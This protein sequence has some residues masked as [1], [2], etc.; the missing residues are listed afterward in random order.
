MR[1]RIILFAFRIEKKTAE[2]KVK[3]LGIQKKNWEKENIPPKMV[4]IYAALCAIVAFV[5]T[6]QLMLLLFLSDP[7]LIIYKH[8]ESSEILFPEMKFRDEGAPERLLRSVSEPAKPACSMVYNVSVSMN[9]QIKMNS[10]SI[11]VTNEHECRLLTFV[12]ESGMYKLLRYPRESIL[13]LFERKDEYHRQAF[14][15]LVRLLS[16][17]ED[18]ESDAL[19][20]DV[21]SWEETMIVLPKW[22]T[23]TSYIFFRDDPDLQLQ[24]RKVVIQRVQQ[25]SMCHMYAPAILQY[26]L[27]SKYSHMRSE[28]SIMNMAKFVR[29]EYN[30]QWL[31]NHVFEGKGILSSRFLSLILRP[32]KG[33]GHRVV[34]F[35]EIDETMLRQYGPLLLSE[36]AVCDDF[37]VEGRL[38]YSLDGCNATKPGQGPV[39]VGCDYVVFENRLTY[40]RGF[41]F[42]PRCTGY[43]SMIIVGVRDEGASRRFLVQNWWRRH[44]FIEISREYLE[45]QPLLSPSAFVVDSPPRAVPARFAQPARR[46]AESTHLDTPETEPPIL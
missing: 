35:D 2:K 43:H 42:T 20:S 25:K 27:V 29:E 28:P 22:Q 32:D 15:R 8:P 26:Y 5:G 19:P 45:T 41:G 13:A 14:K 3:E 33:P 44:Q 18:F 30:Q 1:Q 11:P 17:F 12:Y 6:L 21:M 37:G 16:D 9:A 10:D 46:Y 36:F 40:A 4:R 23:K 38:V 24:G 7:R 34:S 39:Y 31:K